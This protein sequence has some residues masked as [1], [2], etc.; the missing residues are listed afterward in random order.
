MI[1]KIIA[2]YLPQFHEIPENNC[3]WGKGYTDWVAVK[4]SVPLFEGHNQPRVPENLFYYSLNSE[5]K[6]MEYM[7]LEY[8]II[9]FLLNFT[10][11]KNLLKLFLNQT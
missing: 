7:D 9:G 10:F 6:K 8:I 2:N 5:R 3:F 4:K 1:T 11:W